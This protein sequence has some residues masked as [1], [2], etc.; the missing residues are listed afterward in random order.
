V[1]IDYGGFTSPFA[2]KT[3]TT[4]NQSD[5]WFIGFTP[6]L[7]AGVWT[8]ANYRSI[9]F[10]SISL[11]QGSNVAL[12]VFGRFF[13]KVFADPTIGLKEQFEFPRPIDVPEVNCD[14]A[15]IDRGTSTTD[16]EDYF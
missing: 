13:K 2:G 6:E 14:E 15:D 1:Y 5:G 3:G 11:G 7:V 9:H 4:Q 8:G 12:P 10:R 16:Y